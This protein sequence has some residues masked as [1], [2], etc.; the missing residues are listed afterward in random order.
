[1]AERYGMLASLKHKLYF[2]PILN[3]YIKIL[4]LP[5]ISRDDS[6]RISSYAEVKTW[7]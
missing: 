1:M 4:L 3:H 7:Y 2:L 5:L 6:E